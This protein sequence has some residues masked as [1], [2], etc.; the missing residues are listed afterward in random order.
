[1]PS[2]SSKSRW[3]PQNHPMAASNVVSGF[4]AGGN[5][6]HTIVSSIP[7]PKSTPKAKF[8]DDLIDDEEEEGF[9]WITNAIDGKVI[10][11]MWSKRRFKFNLKIISCLLFFRFLF[12]LV[13][14]RR[15]WSNRSL[16]ALSRLREPTLSTQIIKVLRTWY[17][18]G[19]R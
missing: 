17:S 9:N 15:R 8:V 6:G 18:I 14:H 12:G 1:M 5:K 3:G 10:A 2:T 7:P 16:N 11:N 19:Y 4:V 13:A